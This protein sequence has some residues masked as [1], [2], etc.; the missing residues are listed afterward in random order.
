M[1]IG[2][3]RCPWRTNW[4]QVHDVIPSWRSYLESSLARQIFHEKVGNSFSKSFHYVTTRD[5]IAFITIYS[6]FERGDRNVTESDILAALWWNLWISIANKY[7][8]RHTHKHTL[9][10]I[11]LGYKGCLA[12]R[13][14]FKI[15][16]QVITRYRWC[17]YRSPANSPKLLQNTF[18]HIMKYVTYN[19][20]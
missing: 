14:L 16:A 15:P 5:R 4:P 6:P 12:E 20:R 13:R 19:T 7:T 9:A 17:R 8:D 2:L 10:F 11:Y 3:D 1:I 18:P